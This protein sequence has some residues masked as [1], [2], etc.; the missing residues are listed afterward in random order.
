MIVNLEFK[1]QPSKHSSFQNFP[2][3]FDLILEETADAD[4]HTVAYSTKIYVQ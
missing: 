4:L 3:E 1:L 2:T